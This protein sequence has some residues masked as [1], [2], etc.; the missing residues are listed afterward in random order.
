M[1]RVFFRK[2]ENQVTF[3]TLFLMRLAFSA[4][5]ADGPYSMKPGELMRKHLLA[6]LLAVVGLTPAAVVL[7][8]NTPFPVPPRLT[9]N[10]PFPVPPHFT[11][12]TPFPVPPHITDSVRVA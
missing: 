4:P 11:D 1:G 2:I 3:F 10:T 7:A 12:N 8:D 6:G 5:S 9:D